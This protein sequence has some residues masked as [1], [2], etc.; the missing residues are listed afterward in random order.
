MKCY[1]EW[2]IHTHDHVMGVRKSNAIDNRFSRETALSARSAERAKPEAECPGVLPE[3][4]VNHFCGY[5][6][7]FFEKIPLHRLNYERVARE[8]I[9]FTL[10]Q[11]LKKKIKKKNWMKG[12]KTIFNIIYLIYNEKRRKT[13]ILN[14]IKM[15]KKFFLTGFE[16][17]S[18]KS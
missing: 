10:F 15:P 7:P 6:R 2:S 11:T 8:V 1:C 17:T 16:R 14:T 4:F 5:S 12:S 9:T 13:S 18:N 3:N